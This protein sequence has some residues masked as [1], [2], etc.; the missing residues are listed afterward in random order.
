MNPLP[1]LRLAIKLPVAIALLTLAGMTAICV[2]SLLSAREMARSASIS[3]LTAAAEGAGRDLSDWIERNR[4]SLS[5]AASDPGVGQGL[6]SLGE[7]YRNLPGDPEGFLRDWSSSLRDGGDGRG[8][9]LDRPG[10]GSIYG[11]AHA[12]IHPR[13]RAMA[14]AQD[15]AD[16]LLVTRN[17]EVVYSVEKRSDFGARIPTGP[18]AESS[19]GDVFR[20]ALAL[21]PGQT[22][23]T[24]LAPYAPLEGEPTAFLATPVPGL[25]GEVIG[26]LVAQLRLEP[27][28]GLLHSVSW[29]GDT[30]DIYVVGSD[31]RSRSPSRF[32]G[33]LDLLEPPPALPQVGAASLGQE[34]LFLDSAG[35]AGQTVI[36]VVRPAGVAGLDWSIIAERNQEEVF[37]VLAS[38]GWNMLIY[39]VVGAVFAATLG[40]AAAQLVI[41]PLVGLTA[42]MRAL[43][44]KRYDAA[45]LGGRRGDEIGDLARALAALRNE[46]SQAAILAAERNATRAEQ[47]RVVS[48]LGA[49]LGRLSV[50][51]LTRPVEVAFE[52]AYEGLRQDVNGTMARLS[53]LLSQ[54]VE[55]AAQI[56][57]KAQE[58]SS[59]SDDLS[60]RT[61]NQA[62]TLEQT[63]AAL[64]QLTASVKSS[65]QGAA[66]VDDVVDKAR[67]EAE[68][69]GAVV[70]DAVAAMAEIEHSSGEISQI[71]GVIDDI[72]FQ[73]NLLALN[74]G[75]EAAR[76]GEAGKGFAVVASEVRTLAQRSSEAAKQI[77]VLIGGSAQHVRHGVDLVGR[78]GAALT[79]I[80]DRVAHIS[81][82]VSDIAGGT[83]EQAVGLGEINGGVN[84]LDQVTQQN[85]AMVEQSTA[86]SHALTEDARQ[87]AELVSRFRLR[88]VGAPRLAVVA[89][90]HPEGPPS[91]SQPFSPGPASLATAARLEATTG[92]PV[93]DELWNDF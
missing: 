22:A 6:A 81:E 53:S 44:E 91:G 59:A 54:V 47:D 87:L 92:R 49:A 76:A 89:P 43:V 39:L 34:G 38:L 27:L 64:D 78:A 28:A 42:S 60:R 80:V 36:A 32:Q 25:G 41:A 83:K 84:Q 55:R 13:L 9:N 12:L 70:R 63:A 20:A 35:L 93:S 2:I 7:A 31:G 88:D 33:R 5:A 4:A 8:P 21:Q 19:L 16:L 75:V 18:L 67:A 69:S 14:K 90:P 11:V 37:G 50:G 23:L 58:I 65:A 51:D 86:A 10:E 26:L 29:L 56:S 73:T 52:P 66:E 30:D 62:A 68:Q 3:A 77:K 15:F 74:A 82:L 71:I 24:D 48:E 40:W 72:A 1:R 57:H 61:E 46:L 17:G 79:S 45:I 85:A